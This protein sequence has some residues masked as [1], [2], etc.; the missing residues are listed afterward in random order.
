MDD[1]PGDNAR[2]DTIRFIREGV[3]LYVTASLHIIAV[4]HQNLI[5]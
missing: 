4:R 5:Y 2:M 1:I 3:A